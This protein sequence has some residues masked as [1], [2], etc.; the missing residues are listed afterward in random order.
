MQYFQRGRLELHPE[1]AGTRY[2]IQ[3]GH[4]GAAALEAA[5]R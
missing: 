3:L 2:E 1:L 4:L 5:N